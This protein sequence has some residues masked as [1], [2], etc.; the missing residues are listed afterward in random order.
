MPSQDNKLDAE[1][2]TEY[3]EFELEP[4]SPDHVR[5]ITTRIIEGISL[6]I[7]LTLDRKSM[8]GVFC[9]LLMGCVIAYIAK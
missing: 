7:S 1:T 6:N 9:C 8:G 2:Q 5:E 4:P 3:R